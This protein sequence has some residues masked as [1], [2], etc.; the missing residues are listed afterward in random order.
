MRCVFPYSTSPKK[1]AEQI[2]T[3][4]LSLTPPL[5]PMSWG[6]SQLGMVELSLSS[7]QS[8]CQDGWGGDSVCEDTKRGQSRLGAMLSSFDPV[9]ICCCW[10]KLL[11]SKAQLYHKSKWVKSSI[12]CVCVGGLLTIM[13]RRR[14]DRPADNTPRRR[15][16]VNIG[17]QARLSESCFAFLL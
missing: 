11:W 7:R 3:E 10:W 9:V 15:A 5:H 2:E 12:E 17:E 1:T 16:R 13:T 8:L 4:L 14:S 6:F